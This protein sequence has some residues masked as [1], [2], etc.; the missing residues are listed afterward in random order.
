MF[1]RISD[2]SLFQQN[3]ITML[4]QAEN[5]VYFEQDFEACVEFWK[6][7]W[8]AVTSEEWEVV[9]AEWNG[10]KLLEEGYELDMVVDSL[11]EAKERIEFILEPIFE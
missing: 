5:E 8:R 10:R 7:M 9:D 6:D 2:V 3:T 4:Y 1:V 11:Q